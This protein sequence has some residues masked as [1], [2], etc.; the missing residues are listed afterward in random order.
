[1]LAGHTGKIF[2][3][4]V[5]NISNGT[6]PYEPGLKSS[7]IFKSVQEIIEDAHLRV[8]PAKTPNAFL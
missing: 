1:M 7:S 2:Q 3:S 6:F 8:A 5:Q 4:F